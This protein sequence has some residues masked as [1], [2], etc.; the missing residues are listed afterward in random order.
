MGAFLLVLL[1][2]ARLMGLPATDVLEAR[3]TRIR[4]S[5]TALGVDAL[6]VTAFPNIRYLS[7]HVG[8]AGV[9]VLTRDDAHLLVD[10]RY[11]AAVKA[12][13]DSSAACPALRIWPVPAS[14]DEAL[15]GCLVE[16]GVISVGIEAA[17]LT[18]ARY[19]WLQAQAGARNTGLTFHSTSRLVEEARMVK[20][21]VE[22]G[23]AA[24]SRPTAVAR[25]RGGIGCGPSRRN[26]THGRGG[27]RG[28]DPGRRL[29]AAR[30]RHDRRV[31]PKRG[32]AA[33]PR[34]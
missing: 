30:L 12:L 32:A 17:H 1:G 6:V 20:D 27:D 15:L 13:Q 14:Y 33:P 8:S 24:R 22:H 31:R 11:E 25:R 3:H 2:D 16:I 10:F 19:E 21:A 34:G 18:V 7:N 5:L 26:R 4:R 29:R 28:G 9:L 23:D